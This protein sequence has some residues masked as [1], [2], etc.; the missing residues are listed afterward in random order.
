[1]Q[2]A[3]D[4]RTAPPVTP[5]FLAAA[6]PKASKEVLEEA[7]TLY[8]DRCTEC[9]DLEMLDSRSIPGWEK[10]VAGMSRRASLNSAQQAAI[11]EYLAAAQK[12]V[13]SG[14]AD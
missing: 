7:R 1:M 6:K 14:K 3:F 13:E 12:V 4:E 2:S 8:T 9:H 11:I 5:A 10:T